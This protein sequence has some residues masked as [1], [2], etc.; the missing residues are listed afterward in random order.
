MPT[1]TCSLSKTT[2]AADAPVSAPPCAGGGAA[3]GG[4]SR[5]HDGVTRQGLHADPGPRDDLGK[6]KESGTAFGSPWT[7][8]GELFFRERAVPNVV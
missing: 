7:K 3:P 5:V 6:G 8:A 4:G 2:L 1:A